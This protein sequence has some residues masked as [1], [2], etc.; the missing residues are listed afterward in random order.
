MSRQRFYEIL[1]ATLAWATLLGMVVFSWLIPAWVAVFIILFD[2]YWLLK[3]IYMSFHLRATY[4]EMKRNLKIDWVGELEKLK[5]ESLKS[6]VEEAG[7]K[8][9]FDFTLSTLDSVRDWRDIYHLVI[10]PM[11]REPYEVVRESFESLLQAHYPK[12]KF[13]VVLALEERAGPEVLRMGERIKQEYGGKFFKFFVA[14]HPE[15]LPG[16]IPGK[17]SN[18]SWAAL[19]VKEEIIDPLIRRNSTSVRSAIS[20]RTP[21]T[22][23]SE[24]K[25]DG[26]HVFSSSE[27]TGETQFRRLPLEGEELASSGPRSYEDILVSVF[28]IDTQ[29]FPEYFGRVAYAYLTVKNP[30]RCIYQ[31]I[32]LFTNN[33]HEAPA[34]SRVASF[35]ASFWQ[36]MQQARPERL[37]SF[38]SQT[39]PLPVVLDIGYWD[40]GIVSE[41]S[42]VFWQGFLRYHG[43]FR[44]EPLAYP[45]S[46]DANVAPTFWGTLKNI[47]KQ[48][49]R[50]TWGVENVP[51]ML[52]GFRRDPLIPKAKKRYWTFNILESFH[53]LATNSLMIFAL[54]WLPLIL[55]GHVFG[56]TM[57]SYNLPRITR[58]IIDLSLLGISGSVVMGLLLLP[59]KPGA[60]LTVIDYFFYVVQWL[61]V[62][63]T[64]TVFGAVPGLESQTRL[65]LGGKYRLGFWVTPKGRKVVEGETV[66]QASFS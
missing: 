33:I 3:T 49:R 11:Y 37:T 39:L 61:L 36:M 52:E 4:A 7:Q 57:L 20:S 45:V 43:D 64:L 46:M 12:D 59:R 50:W 28:D 18:Q 40:K 19:R 6:K 51:Y 62:P 21:P 16:E 25:I 10:L 15:N 56:Q 38:S 47:Y 14:V 63:I 55:G 30:L 24:K 48:Q 42:R 54:G 60:R 13:I 32:P 58:F 34:P 26:L 35:S 2:T 44:V 1:P 5:V 65:A 9:T 23:G 27:P 29:A 31:P 53:S 41:D 17:S 8:G 22:V 66:K